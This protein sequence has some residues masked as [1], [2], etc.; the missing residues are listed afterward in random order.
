MGRELVNRWPCEDDV[1]A[2]SLRE[3][4]ERSCELHRHQRIEPDLE[5]VLRTAQREVG[6][7]AEHRADVIADQGAETVEPLL[8]RAADECRDVPAVVA[9][10][11]GTL[12]PCATSAGI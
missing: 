6:V 10:F 2:D 8:G 7:Q 3:R 9:T 5:D 1:R 11:A 12:T 4:A